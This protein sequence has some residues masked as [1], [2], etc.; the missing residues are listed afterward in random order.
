DLSAKPDRRARIHRIELRT[1]CQKL[2]GQR[3]L[4]SPVRLPSR[5]FETRWKERTHRWYLSASA[6]CKSRPIRKRC[7][8]LSRRPPPTHPVRDGGNADTAGERRTPRRQSSSSPAAALGK[9]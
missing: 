5:Y 2:K 9:P 3:L 7:F 1:G 8:D 4:Y 6:Q